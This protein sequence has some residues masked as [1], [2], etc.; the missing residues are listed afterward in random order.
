MREVVTHS[1]PLDGKFPFASKF[2]LKI[3]LVLFSAA[4]DYLKYERRSKLRQYRYLVQYYDSLDPASWENY[5]RTDDIVKASQFADKHHVTR[6][7]DTH[8]DEVVQQ[9]GHYLEAHRLVWLN[10]LAK[11]NR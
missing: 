3:K 1:L 9:K 6:I 2:G 4:V 5:K 10:Q 7:I 11:E 8:S